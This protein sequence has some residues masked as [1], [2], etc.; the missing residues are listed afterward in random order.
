MSA[1]LFPGQGSQVVGMGSEFYTKFDL[2]KKIF[3]EADEK[4][5]YPISKIILEGPENEL[6]LTKNTQPAILTVSYSIFNV[7]KMEFGF[8]FSAFK[9]FAGHSLGEYSALV[10]SESLNFADALYLLHERGKAMQEAVPVGKGG[11]IA[12]LGVKIENIID[13][14]KSQNKFEGVCEI[15]NDNADGQVI[16]SGNIEKIENFKTLLKEKKIK[17]IPLKVSAPFHC[18]L[19]KPATEIM[20]EKILNTKFKN[21]K[22]KI[23]NNVTASPET[24]SDIIKELLI[25]QISSTVRWRESVIKISKNNTKNFIEIGPGKILTGMVKRTI[26]NVNCFSINSIDDIKI[27]NNEFKK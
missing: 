20:R 7:L 4:L 11:M 16:I 26:K 18:T 1:L 8:D 17:S 12:V 15:A 3:K 2:V 23:V 27:L 9:Y 21:P 22:F 14:L 5:N 25:K 13:L 6:Q 24:N 19:M 10:C